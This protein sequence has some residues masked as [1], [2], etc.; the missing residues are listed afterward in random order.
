LIIFAF[1]LGDWHSSSSL[2][3]GELSID[4]IVKIFSCLLSYTISNYIKK[5]INR[6]NDGSGKFE[7]IINVL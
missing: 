6:S 7:R 5:S 1:L 2:T 3:D 4:E